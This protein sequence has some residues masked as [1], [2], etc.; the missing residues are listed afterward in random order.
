M[1]KQ[2]VLKSRRMMRL[3]IPAVVCVV[4]IAAVAIGTKIWQS[5]AASPPQAMELRGFWLGMR[6]APTNSR[7]AEELGVPAGI[8]GVLVADV[9]PS[10]RALS[11]G[12]APGDV[13]TRVD[14]KDVET[15]MELHA[16]S[17][18][19]DVGRQLQIDILR[20]GRPMAVILQPDAPG[21]PVTAAG[22]YGGRSVATP[23]AGAVPNEG[24][25][26]RTRWPNGP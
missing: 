10:S 22:W 1:T 24:W 15:L 17:A 7:S 13:V 26:S 14:G 2:E 12:L 18:K 25:G 4:A 3:A 8:K 5:S 16:L 19:L 9:Q 21:N 6:L 11:A 20:V 23:A